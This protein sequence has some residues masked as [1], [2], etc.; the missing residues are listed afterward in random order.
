LRP[1]N[2]AQAVEYLRPAG[3]DVST[4][5]E[6]APGRK[7]PMLV[8]DFITN[9]RRAHAEVAGRDPVESEDEEPYDWREA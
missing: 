1:D 6:S 9:A 5:V 2:V 3:V 7:D 4:G 8:R